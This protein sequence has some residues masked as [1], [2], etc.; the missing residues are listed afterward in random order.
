[1]IV[2]AIESSTDAAGV[3]LADG[4]GVLAQVTVAKG[5]RHAETITPSIEWCCATTGV[6]LSEVDAI[7]VDTGPGLFTGLRVG[8][9][10]AK[11]LAYALSKLVVAVSSLDVLLHAATGLRSDDATVM[12]VLDARRGEVVWRRQ[13]FRSEGSDDSAVVTLETPYELVARLEKMDGHDVLLV[14]D[15]AHRYEEMLKMI[16]GVRIAGR[17][18]SS[19]PV[20]VLAEMGVDLATKGQFRDPLLLVPDYVR[21]ADVRI[22]WESRATRPAESQPS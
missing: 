8:V 3:A 10:T 14:G 15:G 13:G 11:A 21:H 20:G 9:G 12:A 17:L 4:S 18:L 1:M 5:R 16:P 2:L 22:N 6:A 7:V 19:P